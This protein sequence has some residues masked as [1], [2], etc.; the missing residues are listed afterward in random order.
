MP[1]VANRASPQQALQVQ[2]RGVNQCQTDD[3]ILNHDTQTNAHFPAMSP[4]HTSPTN[5]APLAAN[6]PRPPSAQAHTL[7]QGATA[8]T[9]AGY[10]MPNV[11]GYTT[12]QLHTALRLQ[13]QQQ[14]Q[15]AQ[16]TQQQQV[17]LGRL[18][19]TESN[20]TGIVPDRTT[21]NERIP[22]ELIED[23]LLIKY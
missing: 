13:H 8:G 22:V 11:P 23:S 12:E 16:Q 4:P 17:S 3:T 7:L 5:S 18:R 9:R 6:S 10:Y 20:S 2:V 19:L 1:G 15:Q 14:Q 21:D